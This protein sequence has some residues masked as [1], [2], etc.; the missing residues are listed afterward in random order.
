MTEIWFIRHSE[1]DWNRQ[2]RLQGWQDTPL[3]D[4]GQAQ[5]RALAERLGSEPLPFDALYSSDLQR[6]L[7]TATPVS[8]ALGLRVRPEPG[9][10]ERGFGVLEGLDLDRIDEL[11]PAAAAAWKSRDPERVVDGGETL[12]QFNARIVAAVEDLAQRHDGQRLLAFTHGAVLD[13]IWRQASGVSLNA[14]RQATLFNVSINRVSVQ[15]RQWRI[16]DWGDVKHIADEVGNDV[17]P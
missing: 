13:I 5:A 1:T 11:A 15:G 4:A 2:R 17:Q 7:A 3:N 16:L 12:G 8:Q 14:P 10:R 6:T 9:I